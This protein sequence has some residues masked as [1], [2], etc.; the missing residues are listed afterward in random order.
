MARLSDVPFVLRRVG[1]ITFCRRVWTEVQDDQL[2]SWAASL[3]YAWLFAIFPFMIFLLTLIPYLPERVVEEAYTQIPIFLYSVMATPSAYTIWENV[4]KLFWDPP[5]GLFSIGLLITIWAASRGI[6]MTMTAL[7]RCYEV[8]RG[9][10]FLRR[11]LIAVAITVV[12]AVMIIAVLVLIPVGTMATNYAIQHWPEKSTPIPKGILWTWNAARYCLA[13]ILMFMIVS[14]VYHF[15][16]AV[17]Q[18]WRI[19]TPGAVFTI[20]V[21]FVL[22]FV[23]RWY[24]NSIGKTT[25]HRT[26]G[27]VGG[28]AVLLLF[29][30]LDALVLMIGAEINSEIDYEVLGVERGCRDFRVKPHAMF[31]ERSQPAAAPADRTG[32]PASGRI[33]D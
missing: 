21:W 16:I 28:V 5:R 31:D 1:V 22:A 13:G 27:T 32:E 7:D 26:Y 4:E 33:G 2:F 29:F 17:R 18:R 30:Y 3:A 19:F 23:F 11:G 10:S 15:G 6:N 25:Y 24:V 14:V 8:E 12:V 20:A 9:R